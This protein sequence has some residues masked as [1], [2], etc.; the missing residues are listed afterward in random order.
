MTSSPSLEDKRALRQRLR[1]IRAAVGPAERRRA[2]LQIRRLALH[3]GLLGRGR[4]IAFYLPAKH[5]ID[6]LP[7]LEQARR[8]GV[9]AYL[10]V[11][12]ARSQRKLFF[13]RL[14]QSA[15]WQRNRFGIGEYGLRNAQRLRASAMQQVFVPLLG[16][17]RRGFRLGMGGGY[18]D[19]SLAFLAH[20]RVWRK[21]LLIGVAFAAQEVERVPAEAWD[22]PLNAILTERGLLRVSDQ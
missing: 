12:P 9:K 1:K 18:Y 2:G 7:L 11:V 10:P 20:R 16:F 3:H 4:S 15:H 14:G 6:L 8:M 22:I 19:A 13:T 5:E 21:P 17:D